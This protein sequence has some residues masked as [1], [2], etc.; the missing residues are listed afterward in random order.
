M[1]I[2][3]EL[4]RFGL[5]SEDRA[6]WHESGMSEEAFVDW[7]T[8]RVARRPTGTRARNVYGADD[9]HDFARR[10]ILQALNLKPGDRLLEVAADA[11]VPRRRRTA[12]ARE[13]LRRRV[14]ALR[15]GGIRIDACA[16]RHVH[17]AAAR[18]L[19]PD[20]RG[21]RHLGAALADVRGLALADR[22]Q[23]AN[24]Q[25][26]L[27]FYSWDEDARAYLP[28]ALNVMSFRGN[29]VSDVT[30]FIVRSTGATEPEAYERFPD[31]P[32]DPRRL[33]GTFERFGL[34]ERLEE[35][36]ARHPGTDRLA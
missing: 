6:A 4:S 19:V 24:G 14:G 30:A 8:D 12:R 7:L 22:A 25:P 16:G 34:P 21:D 35:P 3:R 32:F 28:F 29:E 1:D 27:A 18:D 31:Q 36:G 9:V 2:E 33:A 13:P 10:A 11:E 20:S 26:A 23:R 15:C 5:G 17:D